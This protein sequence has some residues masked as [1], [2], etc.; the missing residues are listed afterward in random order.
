MEE[1]FGVHAYGYFGVGLE[2]FF[3]GAGAWHAGFHGRRFA[4][5]SVAVVA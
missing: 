3:G 2:W 5:W 1:L 4:D